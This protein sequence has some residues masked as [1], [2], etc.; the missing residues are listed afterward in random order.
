MVS[1]ST[2]GKSIEIFPFSS[3]VPTFTGLSRPNINRT[4]S[5]A[6]LSGVAF[7]ILPVKLCWP[8]AVNE[9]MKKNNCKNRKSVFIFVCILLYRFKPLSELISE[10][11]NGL[12]FIINSVY[13]SHYQHVHHNEKTYYTYYPSQNGNYIDDTERYSGYHYSQ[14]LADMKTGKRLFFLVVHNK[15]HN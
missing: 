9:E 6:G 5:I 1:G 13:Q 3:T 12:F 4:I 15:G 11:R 7:S 14:R 8:E 10:D 2:S